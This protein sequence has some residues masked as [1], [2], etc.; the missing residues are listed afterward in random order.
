MKIVVLDGYA[1]NPGDL[2]WENLA[3]LGELVVY[4]R[5]PAELLLERAAGAEVLISNKAFLGA[6]EMAALPELRY[7]GLQATGVNVVDLNAARAHGI[8]VSNVPAYSTPS[9]AQHAFALLL[10]LARGVGL[11]AELVRQGAWTSCPDFA[12]QKTPQVELTNKVFGVVGF[13]DIGQEAARIAAAFGMRILVHTR[14]PDPAAHPQVNFVDL[15]QLLG[16]SDVVSLHCPLT[17]ETK[18]LINAERLALMKTSAYLINTSR[19]LLVDEKALAEALR[20]GA[21]AG[22]GLDVLSAEPPPGDNPLLTAPNCYITPHLAWA[23]FA[24]RQRLI[25]E[26]V[27]NLR[28]F[29]AGTPRNQV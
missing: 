17:P 20:R 29:L 24:A 28:A 27:E 2:S 4:D 26:I 15:D 13:G 25:G 7:I 1:T 5:T 12:F 8:I 18:S 10:E 14:T 6:A 9:V 23:T 22:A 19:G 16:A 21:I 3:E 11:H